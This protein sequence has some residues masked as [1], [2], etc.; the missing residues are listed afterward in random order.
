[1]ALHR[2]LDEDQ[3]LV[4]RVLQVVVEGDDVVAGRLPETGQVGVVLPVVAEQVQRHDVGPGARLLG[5][6]LPAP[7]LAAVV[8]EDQLVAQ[9]GSLEDLD[10]AVDGPLHDARAVEHG[11]DQ[12]E[13]ARVR[14]GDLTGS[15]GQ[16][17]RRR[18]AVHLDHL[19]LHLSGRRPT[20]GSL[21]P[22][23][24]RRRYPTGP[25]TPGRRTPCAAYPPGV[26]S[27]PWTD[28]PTTSTPRPDRWRSAPPCTA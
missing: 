12:G 19:A 17:L 13:R 22:G 18:S 15:G 3:R 10:D 24:T 20:S 1:M 9:P 21:V 28:T 25:V 2:L 14:V 6:D 16:A 23:V 11:N 7:V 4:G 5:D 27:S 8:D 26:Y